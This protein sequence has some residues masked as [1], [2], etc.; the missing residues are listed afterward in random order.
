[1]LKI[2]FFLGSFWLIQALVQIAFKISS[3]PEHRF[4]LWFCAGHAIGV[5]SLWFLVALYK[6]M[7]QSVAFGLAM[8]GAFLAAQ[9]ALFVVF[10]PTTTLTQWIGALAICVGMVLLA[11]GGPRAAGA[12]AAA[13]GVPSA[14]DQP[15]EPVDGIVQGRI[16]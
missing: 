12:A 2:V 1:M 7:N 9:L 6:Q 8:G 5:P 13:A 3:L 4:L 16:D 15:A 11:A 14:A 10:R